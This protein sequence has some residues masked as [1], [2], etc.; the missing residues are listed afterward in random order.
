VNIPALEG[1]YAPAA[2]AI[3]RGDR[4]DFEHEREHLLVRWSV[5]LGFAGSFGLFTLLTQKLKR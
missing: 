4:A 2:A 3:Q 1:R 5:L